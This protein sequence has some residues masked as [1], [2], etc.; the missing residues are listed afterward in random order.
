MAF[1][2]RCYSPLDHFRMHFL[3]ESRHEVLQRCVTRARNYK[4]SVA[5]LLQHVL[6]P[7][8][9]VPQGPQALQE[10]VERP[11]VSDEEGVAILQQVFYEQQ[12]RDLVADQRQWVEWYNVTGPGLD[13]AGLKRHRSTLNQL[14][15]LLYE[16]PDTFFPTFKTE[17]LQRR[18][19]L[20]LQKQGKE[21]RTREDIQREKQKQEK[22]Q[23]R[24]YM[25]NLPS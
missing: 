7:S 23:A 21:W 12:M 2:N 22:E 6:A 17:F 13:S 5:N 24:E 20:N 25:S 9:L 14:E 15:C 19:A 1:V 8:S 18:R 11:D 4:P 16:Q 3:G 10:L